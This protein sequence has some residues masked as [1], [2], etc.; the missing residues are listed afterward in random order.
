MATTFVPRIVRNDYSV[1]SL[2]NSAQWTPQLTASVIVPAY[3]HPDKLH[4][5]LA[6]LAA[7]TY[8][9]ELFEV[10]VV[11]DNSE[12]PLRLP[13]IKP[14]NTRLLRPPRGRWG[15]AYAV[16]H[17]VAAS[18]ADVIVR[19]DSDMVAFA[20]HL[21]AHMRWN[22]CADYLAVLGHKRFID[23]TSGAFTPEQIFAAVTSGQVR[24]LRGHQ[25][26]AP[27]WIETV[28]NDTN[29][30][31]Q[32]R[33]DSY[34]VFV[35]AT[36]SL[37]RELFDEV[38]GMDPSLPLGSDTEF[39]Y[40]LAQ[41]GAVFVPETTSSAWHLGTSH[42][43]ASAVEG[44]RFR[45]PFVAQRVPLLAARRSSPGRAWQVPYVDIVIDIPAGETVDNVDAAVAPL[46]DATVSDVRVSLVAARGWP[47]G[48][49]RAT[50]L[51]SSA[52]QLRLVAE[53]YRHESR[54]RLLESSPAAD[55]AVP[56]RLLLPYPEA[57]STDTVRRLTA[58][59]D[60]DRAGLVTVELPGGGQ[61]RLE[62]RAAFARAARLAEGDPEQHDLDR[63]VAQIWGASTRRGLA[64]TNR[65]SAS[66]TAFTPPRASLARRAVRTLLPGPVRH[67]LHRLR[68][69]RLPGS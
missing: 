41:A 2:P 69:G 51:S 23:Y 26:S 42:M 19:L 4:L 53:H 44:R 39:A 45:T 55:P 33:V 43:Q 66:V 61:A 40:R 18:C 37:R 1:L 13:P 64:G 8:P 46:L 49:E 3:G 62:R 20:D 50:D 47:E 36:G 38:G 14:E 31:L 29:Q 16:N 63:V 30:L 54:V 34:R 67:R 56:F 22:H 48:E 7:Q 25:H 27:H 5:T 57:T 10:I 9:S 52:A 21:E 59:A 35:G 17:G 28:L 12:P 11:D 24:T 65:R 58:A 6:S 32:A 68:Q 15:S 60:A